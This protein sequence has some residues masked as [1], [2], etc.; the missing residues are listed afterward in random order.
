MSNLGPIQIK[1][2][3]LL[4]LHLNPKV[5]KLPAYKRKT[6]VLLGA[7]GVGRRHIKN[8]LI[9]AHKVFPNGDERS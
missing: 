9:A 3:L 6:L 7:H 2:K 8:S 4:T 1:L 5:V